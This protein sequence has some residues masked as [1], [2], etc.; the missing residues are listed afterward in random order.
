FFQ[1]EDG[2]RDKLVTGVQ[3]CALPILDGVEEAQRG[4][5]GQARMRMQGTVRQGEYPV[6]DGP[7]FATQ[8]EVRSSLLHQGGG[9]GIVRRGQQI[10]RASCRESVEV[11]LGGE[12]VMR[13]L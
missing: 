5:E 12:S 11:S 7:G 2:I 4:V 3:T 1:A 10:G 6:L 8:P 13:V 9:Q